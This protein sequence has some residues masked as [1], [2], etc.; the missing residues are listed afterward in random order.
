MTTYRN[1]NIE[2]LNALSANL[3]AKGFIVW[4][5]VIPENPRVSGNP[6]VTTTAGYHDI[7]AALR[8]AR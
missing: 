2:T 5:I 6:Y 3:Q 1:S 7:T 4:P 8:E